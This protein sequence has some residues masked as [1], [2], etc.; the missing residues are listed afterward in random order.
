MPENSCEFEG[1]S[2]TS[3]LVYLHTGKTLPQPSNVEEVALEIRS[4]SGVERAR[5]SKKESVPS[6]ELILRL[7]EWL[8][9]M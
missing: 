3:K 8:K 2:Q 7:V 4:F 6:R 9:D 1:S 5:Y